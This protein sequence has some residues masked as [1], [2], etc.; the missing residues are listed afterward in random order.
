MTEPWLSI[1]N[2]PV[3]L[4]TQK[5]RDSSTTDTLQGI[6]DAQLDRDARLAQTDDVIYNDDSIQ[7]LRPQVDRLREH[8]LSLASRLRVDQHQ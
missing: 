2:F 7:A 8:Y 6:V 3:S 5:A 4:N 1:P